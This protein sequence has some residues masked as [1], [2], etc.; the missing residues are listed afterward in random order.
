MC[1]WSVIPCL[2]FFY[3]LSGFC[4]L[5]VCA[6]G[7]VVVLHIPP[8][9]WL[10]LFAHQPSSDLKALPNSWSTVFFSGV[11]LLFSSPFFLLWPFPHLIHSL[12]IYL[13]YPSCPFLKELLPLY[14]LPQPALKKY[15]SRE[16]EQI[17]VGDTSSYVLVIKTKER[18]GWI[19]VIV[20]KGSIHDAVCK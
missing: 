15:K 14:I 10:S 12:S 2:L 4:L 6:L 11:F 16:D 20:P 8:Y 19:L 17:R 13:S 7:P 18:R 5:N 1:Y 9:L 3:L